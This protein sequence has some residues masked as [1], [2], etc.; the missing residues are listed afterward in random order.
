MIIIWI[1]RKNDNIF[2]SSLHIFGYAK[3][4]H[5]FAASKFKEGNKILSEWPTFVCLHTC[6]HFVVFQYIYAFVYPN[7]NNEILSI[8]EYNSNFAASKSRKGKKRERNGCDI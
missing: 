5:A 8:W 6:L 7:V 3:K 2:F 1:I 4:N